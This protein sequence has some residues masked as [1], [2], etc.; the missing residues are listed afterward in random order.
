MQS[1]NKLLIKVHV[2]TQMFQNSQ[3]GMYKVVFST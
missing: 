3:L 1:K 2:F